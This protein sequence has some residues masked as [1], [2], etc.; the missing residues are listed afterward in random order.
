[1]IES[2]SDSW[3]DLWFL[4]LA[5]YVASASKDP[6]TKVGSVIVDSKRRIVSLG[7]NGLPTGI[8]DTEERL[9]N[10]E[11]KY[12]LIVHAERNA[13]LFSNSKVENCTIYTWPFMPCSS[14]ASLIIQSGISR[15]VS[16]NS[17]NPRWLEDFF[18][19]TRL[20]SEASVDLVLY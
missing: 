17:E 7:Y 8:E 20:F 3:W 6:S 13:L 12:K 9:S 2:R 11:L 15:V 19:S 16:L 4:G 18:L 1:M 14:C 5:E 10:R